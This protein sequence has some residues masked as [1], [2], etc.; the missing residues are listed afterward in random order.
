MRGL[1]AVCSP[2]L[3]PRAPEPT[4]LRGQQSWPSNPGHG[5]DGPRRL[6]LPALAAL[7]ILFSTAL[8]KGGTRLLAP[9]EP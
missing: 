7:G 8:L 1:I 9:T 6:L 2:A 4:P 5:R 3:L